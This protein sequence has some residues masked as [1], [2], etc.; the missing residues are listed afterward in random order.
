MNKFEER[1]GNFEKSMI[2]RIYEEIKEIKP[3]K[4]VTPPTD[5]ISK[6]HVQKI[7]ALQAEV[8]LLNGDIKEKLI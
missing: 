2:A 6:E 5:A 1:L 7:K 8:D 3:E 4:L